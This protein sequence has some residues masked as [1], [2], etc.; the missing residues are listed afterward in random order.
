MTLAHNALLAAFTLVLT[1]QAQDQP[2]SVPLGSGR[3]DTPGI[4]RTTV[5]EDER[6]SVVRVE[7][8]PGAG[9]VP[10]THPYDIVVIV[11]SDGNAT[12]TN[13]GKSETVAKAGTIELVSKGT[14]H[15]MVNHGSSPLHVVTVAIK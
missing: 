14:V 8:A 6:S 2:K 4:T 7:F 5:K 12:F 11:V 3:Q 1:S 13:G 15:T 9:E 10:H